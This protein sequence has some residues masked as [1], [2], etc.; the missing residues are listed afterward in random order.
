MGLPGR[1]LQQGGGVALPIL[2][3]HELHYPFVTGQLDILAQQNIG[4]PHQRIEPVNGQGQKA[5]HFEPVVALFQMGAL[6]GQDV[7][8]DCG[9]KPR[10]NVDLRADKAQNN[11]G[12]DLTA[13]PAAGDLHGIP[14]LAPQ[15]QVGINGVYAEKQCHAQPEIGERGLPG[16]S[17]F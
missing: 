11:G 4:Q 6:V 10:R 16:E 5:D 14:D 13:L 12:I 9:R 15:A 3:L 1:A 7:L 2:Q 8:P 17:R